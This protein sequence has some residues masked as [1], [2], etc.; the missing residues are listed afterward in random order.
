MF[1]DSGSKP[2]CREGTHTDTGRTCR[3][4]PQGP[5]IEPA[6]FLPFY[7]SNL[8][9]SLGFVTVDERLCVLQ[10]IT[11]RRPSALRRCSEP[12]QRIPDVF[13]PTLTYLSQVW[14]LEVQAQ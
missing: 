9:R 5:G 13:S 6:T 8:Q 3:L 10:V 1:L 11:S 2:Y 14:K 12:P 4:D 7:P